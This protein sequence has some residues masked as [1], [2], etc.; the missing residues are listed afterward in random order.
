MRNET[1]DSSNSEWD[2]D[3]GDAERAEESALWEDD[4][5]HQPYCKEYWRWQHVPDRV[6]NEHYGDERELE[7]SFSGCGEGSSGGSSGGK[8]RSKIPVMVI[9]PEET[10]LMREANLLKFQGDRVAELTKS[11]SE[12]EA[13]LQCLSVRVRHHTSIAEQLSSLTML[14][15]SLT[16]AAADLKAAKAL[17]AT[18]T[19]LLEEHTRAATALALTNTALLEETNAA[20]ALLQTNKALLEEKTNA[21]TTLFVQQTTMLEVNIQQFDHFA[22]IIARAPR[23]TQNSL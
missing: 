3:P 1:G 20:T 10:M 15:A 6:W 12:S 21:A 13:S 9:P 14:E 8:H 19:A 4:A 5:P 18:N 17:H 2:A 16:A 23:V 22:I 11:L 7:E